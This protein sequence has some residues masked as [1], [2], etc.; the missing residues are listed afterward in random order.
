MVSV[1]DEFERGAEAARVVVNTVLSPWGG[2]QLCIDAYESAVRLASDLSMTVAGTL[3]LEPV[4][5][6]AATCASLTRDIGATQVSAARW[7]LDA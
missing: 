3:Q 5:S 4:R 2:T 6:F 1:T 7:F